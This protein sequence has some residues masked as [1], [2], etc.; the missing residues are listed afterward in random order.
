MYQLINTNVGA[1]IDAA[2][3]LGIT[4]Y[5]DLRA[6]LASV[7]VSTDAV[8]QRRYRDYWRMNVGRFGPAFYARYFGLLSE[9]QRAGSADVRRLGTPAAD[10]KHITYPSGHSVPQAALVRESL[11]WFDRYLSG[12]P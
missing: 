3:E 1:V 5:S 11:A 4:A 12:R 7:D 6:S 10:K 9:T 2:E 8:F